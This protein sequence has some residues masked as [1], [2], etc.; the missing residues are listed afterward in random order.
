LKDKYLIKIMVKIINYYR[1]IPIVKVYENN[2]LNKEIVLGEIDRDK[3][4]M[5]FS[6]IKIVIILLLS[7]Q[8][9]ILYLNSMTLSQ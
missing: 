5:Q 3:F 9:R 4:I 8:E 6:N 1:F 7:N 2:N